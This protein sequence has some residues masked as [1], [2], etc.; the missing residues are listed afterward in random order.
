[1]RARFV[2]RRPRAGP[3]GWPGARGLIDFVALT[4]PRWP[5]VVRGSPW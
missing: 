1:M 4:P 3:A 5:A 2:Q